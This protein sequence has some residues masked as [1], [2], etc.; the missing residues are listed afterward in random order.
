MRPTTAGGDSGNSGG[1]SRPITAGGDSGSS[2]EGPS[3]PTEQIINT[4]LQLLTD[5]NTL[6]N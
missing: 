6:E 3:R 1:Q 5:P 4:Q 2:G